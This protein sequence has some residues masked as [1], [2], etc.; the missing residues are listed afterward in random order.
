MAV[1]L[2]EVRGELEALLARPLE[3]LEHATP[4]RALVGRETEL[5][6]LRSAID[7]GRDVVLMGVPGVGKTRL[8]TE[9]DRPVV[10]LQRADHGR[11][12]DALVDM[13]PL[14]VVVDD[15]HPRLDDLRVLRQVR[16]QEGLTFSIIASTWPD[17]V[18]EVLADLPGADLIA[19]DLL[20]RSEMDALVCLVISVRAVRPV[21]PRLR[22]R[23]IV[24]I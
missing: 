20:E 10:F 7:A 3:M 15:A 6:D 1:R 22:R 16:V 23:R 11:V 12:V 9:L 13:K 8:T 4:E 24:E 21:Q 5:A 18:E 19:V 14:A 17:R 2:L